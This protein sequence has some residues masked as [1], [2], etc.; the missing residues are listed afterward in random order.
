MAK[1]LLCQIYKCHFGALDGI[2]NFSSKYKQVI[3]TGPEIPGIF[4]PSE[5]CPEVVL[6]NRFPRDRYIYCHPKDYH[7][8][9]GGAYIYSADSRF[10]SRYP[11]PLHDRI[12]RQ[13]ELPRKKAT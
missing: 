4:E 2:A 13:D 9:F 1:G 11:I 12:E 7:G 3:L 10:P 5:D 6:G 8:M